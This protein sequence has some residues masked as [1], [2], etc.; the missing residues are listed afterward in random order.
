MRSPEPSSTTT[1]TPANEIA[2]P[3]ARRRENRSWP[4][5]T[6]IASVIPGAEATTTLAVPAVVSR[7]PAFRERW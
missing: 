3:A 6:T 5:A 7:S 2:S 1:T 4:M